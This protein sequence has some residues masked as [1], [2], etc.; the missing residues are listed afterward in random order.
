MKRTPR[1]TVIGLLLATLACTAT[2]AAA[3]GIAIGGT[4]AGLG[5][6]QAL[7]DDYRR[8]VPDTHITVVPSLGSSGGIKALLAGAIQLAVS[9]RPL[10]KA[11][12]EAGAV[13][14]EY[15]RTPFVFATVAVGKPDGLSSQNLVDIY[16]GR[17]LHWPDGSRIR[18]ILRPIGDSDSET[19]KAISPAM[20]EA[21]T[22][23]ERRTGML[24]TVTDQETA[25]AIENVPGALGTTTLALLLSEV[26]PLKALTLDGVVPEARSLANGSYPHFK[27]MYL[28]TAPG[29]PAAVHAFCDFVLSAKGRNILQRTGHWTP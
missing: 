21:K 10:S 13:A 8:Q 7:A 17:L 3:Y 26:R 12:L 18:L 9:S 1:R 25:D 27:R 6:M 5:A 11:E 20:R 28:V 4:G 29:A 22:A 2:G 19:I 24:F 15:G 23:A 16:A 14:L